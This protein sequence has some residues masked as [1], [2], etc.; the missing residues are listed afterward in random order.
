[1]VVLVPRLSNRFNGHKKGNP[2]CEVSQG[3]LKATSMRIASPL[4]SVLLYNAEEIFLHCLGG[5]RVHLE[6]TASVCKTESECPSIG[7]W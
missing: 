7:L 6:A 1:M 2:T 4:T 5:F 3:G